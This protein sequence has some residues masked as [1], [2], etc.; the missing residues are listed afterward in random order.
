LY[1]GDLVLVAV[2]VLTFRTA[3]R[4]DKQPGAGYTCPKIC[5]VDHIHYINNKE[6]EKDG[7][8]N[9]IYNEDITDRED[10]EGSSDC[11]RGV[12]GEKFKE[13]TR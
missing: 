8:D 1:L 5:D 6:K 13:Q 2:I 9:C 7:T 12:P 10:N 11:F 3:D 4:L